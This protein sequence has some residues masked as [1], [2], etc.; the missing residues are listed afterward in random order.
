[1]SKKYWETYFDALRKQDWQKALQALN[2][3]L[4]DEPNNSQVHLKIGDIFQK[5]GDMSS[6]IT[7]YH[8]SAWLLVKEGFLQKALAIYKII[9][10]LDPENA[11]AV[12]K[13]KELLMEVESSRMKSA[14]A[15]PSF[16]LKIEEKSEQEAVSGSEPSTAKMDDFFT[17][18]FG[19]VS[20]AGMPSSEM[21]EQSEFEGQAEP[22]VSDVFLSGEESASRIPEFLSSLP[23]E[24]A[25]ELLGRIKPQLFSAGQKIVEEG[26]SGD[27]IFLIKS[28]RASVVAHILGKEIELA[29]LSDGDVFGEVAFLTGR[30][31]TASVI[32]LDKLE[33]IE[34]DRF[35][36]EEMFEKYPDI[37]KK[38]QD[39]YQSH[40]QDTLR[41]VKNRIKK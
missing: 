33:L 1:M 4:K 38:L 23:E 35:A 32:A 18:S 12:A 25:R 20:L 19:E 27:S 22:A 17:G 16:E 3:V 9:L 11:E 31:R 28:G 5:A 36:L 14:S 37:L 40:V 41:K 2:S 39:F 26:D 13:F 24:E 15:T 6:A 21:Q 29:M 8:Q 34:F 10:R 7:A 30:P